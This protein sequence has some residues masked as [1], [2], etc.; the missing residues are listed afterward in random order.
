MSLD[1]EDM[2]KYEFQ[3]NMAGEN[4]AAV[5]TLLLNRKKLYPACMCDCPGAWH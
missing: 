5:P 2:G 1:K 4:E 3:L